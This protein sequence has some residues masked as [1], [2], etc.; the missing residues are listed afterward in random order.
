M[1]APGASPAPVAER[2]A[3]RGGWVRSLRGRLLLFLLSL[4]A[5]AAAGVATVSYRNVLAEADTIFDYQLRQM[6][7]S[8]RDQGAIADSERAALEDPSLDYVVQVW[9]VDGAITYSSHRRA[10]LPRAAVLGFA[11]VEFDGRR[12]RVFSTVARGRVIQVAQP[13]AVRHQLA[14]AAAWRSVLPLAIAAPLVA[15][16]VWWLVGVSLAPL[17]EI[18][19]A[20]RSRD[21]ETLAPLPLAGLP[22]E[23]EPLGRSLNALLERLRSSFDAQRAFVADAAHELRSPLTALKLQLELVRSASSEAAR[24]Q[25]LRELGAGTDRMQRLI[26]QLLALA[27][28]EPGGAE[29]APADT[30]VTETVRQAT[31]DTVP[32]AAAHGVELELDAPRPQPAR[33]DAAALRI[34]ARNLIDNAVRY[35]GRGGRVQ[36]QVGGDEA[37][38]VVRVDDSGPGIPVAERSR[39]FDRFYRRAGS[40]TTGS[41]LGL[42]IVRA[43]A[44]RHGAEVRLDDSPLGGLR[45]ELRLPRRRPG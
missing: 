35:G 15:L 26:E 45:V 32:L 24:A 19:A 10:G 31:A 23:L 43:I 42:A 34:L 1:N 44:E 18:V 3:R 29:A 13:L 14:A 16:A 17:R 8:L 36:V 4:A 37:A 33:A 22:A 25:A 5:V 11:D 39:V 27:R 40:E 20:V 41:G 9:T 7:L 12:W 38:V 21:A 2:T 6:A 28:A 30:D